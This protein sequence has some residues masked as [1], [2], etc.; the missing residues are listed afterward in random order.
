L[1]T[2]AAGGASPYILAIY[3][4]QT[5]AGLSNDLADTER[6]HPVPGANRIAFSALIAKPEGIATGF[7]YLRNYFFEGG[8]RFHNLF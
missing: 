6:S 2:V 4:G 3:L 8:Y 5:E 1:R 7:L